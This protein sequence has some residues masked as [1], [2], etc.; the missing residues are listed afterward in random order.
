MLRVLSLGILAAAL[1]AADLDIIGTWMATQ[2][3]AAQQ[4]THTITRVGYAPGALVI[5]INPTTYVSTLDVGEG[6]PATTTATYTIAER[7]PTSV[8]IL[9]RSPTGADQPA[10]LRAAGQGLRLTTSEGVVDLVPY[11]QAAVDRARTQQ[12]LDNRPADALLDRPLAGL[13]DGA[14]WTP[15]HARRADFPIVTPGTIRV[16]VLVAAA[17]GTRAKATPALSL[18][19]PT[20]PGTYPL[21]TLVR[22]RV[23]IPPD[24]TTKVTNGT[25]TI[26]QVSGTAISFALT[27]RGA[28]GLV[29]N[30]RMI[31]DVSPLAHR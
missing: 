11:D 6:P 12:A 20:T 2:S 14:A 31:A 22:L 24:V 1:A 13:I 18:N 27:A 10:T 3:E 17:D 25:L 15:T 9:L 21:T 8:G 7:T 30:G 23:D 26:E 29:L 5:T 28:N 16:D 19:L 4:P